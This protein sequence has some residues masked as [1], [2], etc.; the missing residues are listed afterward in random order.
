MIQMIPIGDY[1]SPAHRVFRKHTE[2]IAIGGCREIFL[3]SYEAPVSAW[4]GQPSIM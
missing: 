1:V 3:L 2:L 4:D